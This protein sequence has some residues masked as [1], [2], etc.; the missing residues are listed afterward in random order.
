[1]PSTSPDTRA[2]LTRPYWSIG[3]GVD[4]ATLFVQGG[5]SL[6][7]GLRP[8]QEASRGLTAVDPGVRASRDQPHCRSTWPEVTMDVAWEG[9]LVA[10]GAGCNVFARVGISIGIRPVSMPHP[11]V[12]F[13]MTDSVPT[14]RRP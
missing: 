4:D 2:E 14:L 3:A 12:A 10:L 6:T 13:Q 9:L 7:V 1:M 8:R 5:Q 11:R